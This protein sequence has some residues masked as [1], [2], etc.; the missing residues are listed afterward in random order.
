M[1]R[2][3]ILLNVVLLAGCIASACA[4]ETL[5]LSTFLTKHCS[6]CHRGMDA[7]GGVDI[8]SLQEVNSATKRHW[9][10]IL[11][12]VQRG[13]MPPAEAARPD[14][15]ARREFLAQLVE[16]LD[17]VSAEESSGDDRFIRLSNA[18]LTW[19]LRDVLH[20]DRD[21][22]AELLQDPAG[23]HGQSG[24]LALQMSSGYLESC[25][26]VLQQAV[27][28][29]IPDLGAAPSPYLIHGNDWEQ[30][31][32]LN[33]ND[34]AH[35]AR[36][37]H[38]RYRGPQWL[39]DDFEIPLPPNHFFR[40]YVDDNR[41]EGQFRVRVHLRN[42]AP[43]QGGVLQ[44]HRFSVFFDKGFKSPMHTIGNF[45]VAAR[46]GTQV[47]EL[48]GNVFDFPG[49]DPAAIRED[50][51]PYGVTAHFKYRFLTVQ[52]CSPLYSAADQPVTNHD[53]VIH[54]AGHFIRAD[55]RWIDAWGDEFARENWLKPSH[56]GSNHDTNGKP[57]VYR[58]VMQDTSHAVI[59]RIEFAMPWQWPPRSAAD[60]IDD[61]R[62][63]A[64]RIRAGLLSAATRAWRR[65]LLETEVLELNQQIDEALR[66]ADLTQSVRGVLLGIL[67]DARFLYLT[68]SEQSTRLQNAELIARL[69]AF[70][71]QS[72]PDES[73]RDLVAQD[74]KLTTPT[75][76][77]AV[78]RML[79][80]P[81]S[82]RFIEEF[83]AAFMDFRRLDQ[84][85]VNP[86]YYGWWNPKF[87]DYIKA[88]SVAFFEMLLREDLSCL[89]CLSSDFIVVNDVMARY[90][91]LPVPASGHEFSRVPAPEHSGGLLTLPAFLMAN[92]D[93]EDAS[94]V[95]RG[96]WLRGRLLGDPPRD[97]PPNVPALDQLTE[98]QPN[99][100]S[101]S[102]AAQLKLHGAGICRDCHQDI[103]PWGLALEGF[104]ATGRSR[105]RVLR[106]TPELQRKRSSRPVENTTE[107]RG[108]A[109][110]G[111]D[112]LQKLL[113]DQYASE[114]A[115]S[116]SGL[117]YSWALGRPL[118][119]RDTAAVDELTEQ[120]VAADYRLP[121]LIRAVILRPEFRD[122]SVENVKQ[123]QV[124][125]L[126]PVGR[127]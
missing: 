50:E 20:I 99:A 73:L 114:F 21:Y 54:G 25:L 104:D 109:V 111:S 116:F 120:F 16:A 42:E 118:D 7:K 106:L 126:G 62:Y 82:S 34:L 9:Q 28:L 74:E 69:A 84:T 65:P 35:G 90:Y 12:Q 49:V 61:G 85:A 2:Q 88:Q 19:S 80:D 15:A 70:L 26:A 24:Q 76:L 64:D 67:A 33:R 110:S 72:V 23:R 108:A 40:I 63:T 103:D 97:P 39:E 57:S 53:W 14:P 79:A 59:E 77:A 115:R 18:Q 78:D 43:L 47:F 10:D 11:H 52:N 91:G 68:K 101:F 58:E 31:H 102:T 87:K 1:P 5:R 55:D 96:V 36:R 46:P 66:G 56:G 98:Q 17:R 60:F 29:A 105:N 100:S 6:D 89:N 127:R 124:R 122:S 8:A 30:Q 51:E 125:V 45:T 81:R 94:A 83:T 32:Y 13:E 75:L 37:H 119:Y 27:E 93:G 107:I 92:S 38:R 48:Y 4:D 113:R 3:A 22:S 71:W 44:P 95:H 86:N 123:Q 41:A 117:I 112:E 121:Q